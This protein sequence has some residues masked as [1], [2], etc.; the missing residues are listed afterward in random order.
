MSED[1]RSRRIAV[2]ADSLLSARLDELRDG[3][4]GAMQLP[5]AD[6]DP[7]TARDWVEL[8]AEQVAEYLR[9]GYEV[10]LLDDGT[11]GAELEDALAA[12]GAP[13]LPAYR[14]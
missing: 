13:T 14:S 6:V 10:V 8:T 12:L 3:G 9:T 5:P 7:A 2:V 11:W 1:P 4:W